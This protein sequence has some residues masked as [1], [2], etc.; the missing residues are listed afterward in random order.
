[1]VAR[2][3]SFQKPPTL[4]IPFTVSDYLPGRCVDGVDIHTLGTGI[5]WRSLVKLC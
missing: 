4:Q 3:L 2:E 5:R 1:M